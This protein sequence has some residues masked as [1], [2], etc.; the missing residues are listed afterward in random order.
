MTR[1]EDVELIR[2]IL[3]KAG[4]RLAREDSLLE[5]AGNHLLTFV[6]EE[7]ASAFRR[8]MDTDETAS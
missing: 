1:D 5:F 2:A 8:F 3:R 4:V 6:N 7:Q